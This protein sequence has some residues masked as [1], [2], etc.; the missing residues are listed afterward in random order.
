[1]EVA[2]KTS[3][4]W[5]WHTDFEGDIEIDV[6]EFYVNLTGSDLDRMIYELRKAKERIE[7]DSNN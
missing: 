6:N 5:Y 4:G 3:D 1:L 2:V 7:D